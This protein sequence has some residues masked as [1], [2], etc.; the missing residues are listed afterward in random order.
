MRSKAFSVIIP[1]CDRPAALES[2]LN[3]ILEQDFPASDFE[4]IVVNDGG[5]ALDLDKGKFLQCKVPVLLI[6][7]PNQGPA[8]ARNTA[9]KHSN[10]CNLAFTDDDCR[11]DRS[12]LKQLHCALQKDPNKVA[13][14]RT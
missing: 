10:A 9:V 6:E 3:S 11:A 13:G 2:C 8:A 4:I 14:G 12:W 1:T 7:Q 5:C